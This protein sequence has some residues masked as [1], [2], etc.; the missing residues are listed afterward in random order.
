MSRDEP[1]RFESWV[2]RQIREAMERGAFDNLPGAGR[3][4][5]LSDDPDWWIKS[6]M[7]REGIKPAV[8]EAIALRR[9]VDALQDTLADV[10]TREAARAICDDLNARIKQHYLSAS[11]RP[12]VLVRRVDVDAELRL[13]E[14][15][16]SL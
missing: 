11:V 1:I 8:P 5:E 3:P 9:E 6:K 4:L 16:R 12:T 7:E 14:Q 10:H 13:W 2:D 15:R